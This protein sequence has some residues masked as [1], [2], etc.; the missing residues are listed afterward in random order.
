MGKKT[1]TMFEDLVPVVLGRGNEIETTAFFGSP[2]LTTSKQ[3]T[4]LHN[5]DITAPHS[6][7]VVGNHDNQQCQALKDFCRRNH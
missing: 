6:G 4:N 7:L 2:L 5:S 1:G 3:T